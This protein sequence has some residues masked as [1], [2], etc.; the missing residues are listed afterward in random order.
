MS[1]ITVSKMKKCDFC[2]KPH[3][4]K[5]FCSVICKDKYHNIHNPRGFYAPKTVEEIIKEVDDSEHPFSE[6]A[7]QG[8]W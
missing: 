1:D 5:R 2:G 6:E 4:R 7:L 8:G 3:N